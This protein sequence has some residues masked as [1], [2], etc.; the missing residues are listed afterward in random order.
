VGGRKA[1]D[2]QMSS[3]TLIALLSYL[4]MLIWLMLGMGFLINMIQRGITSLGR[5]NEILSTPLAILS[6]NAVKH[7]TTT[8]AASIQVKSFSFV[9]P[10]GTIA[11]KDLTFDIPSGA[12]VEIIGRTGSGK[13]TI[14]KT[15][16]SFIVLLELQFSSIVLLKIT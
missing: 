3:G 10:D 6:R 5:I 14:L 16:C 11:L 15:S 9:Y 4:Q 13:S 1:I 12:I 2:G 7:P 8:L